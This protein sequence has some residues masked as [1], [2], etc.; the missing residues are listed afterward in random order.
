M[1]SKKSK[2]FS[3]RNRK[4]KRF[5]RPKAGDLQKNKK[6]V[7]TKIARDFPAEIGN[8]S[9]FPAD[10][11]WSP[12]KKRSSLKLE[13]IFRPKSQIQAVFPV[14]NRWSPKKKC[15]HRNNVTKSGVSPQK[16]LIWT[17]ICAPEASSLLIS[18]GHSPRLGGHKQSV[19]G[20][21]PRYAP[22]WRRVWVNAVFRK[23]YCFPI[24]YCYLASASYTSEQTYQSFATYCFKLSLIIVIS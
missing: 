1:R 15:L 10:Y 11:R 7:F 9:N 18:S 13:G 16:T 6:K 23:F 19:G 2:G 5:F 3:C 12:K 14:E 20:A 17:S 22:P 8:L 21:R 24:C 4:F